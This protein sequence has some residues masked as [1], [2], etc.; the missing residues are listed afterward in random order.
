M[1][2]E[3]RAFV[4][5]LMAVLFLGLLGV[6]AGCQ[7]D[8]APEATGTST[9]NPT[10]ATNGTDVSATPD[11]ETYVYHAE[12][13]P[14]SYDGRNGFTPFACLDGRILAGCWAKVGEDIPEGA[15][16]EYEGQ[17]D[18]YGMKLFSIGP[19][20]SVRAQDG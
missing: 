19:D 16:P 15:K 14:L 12:F 6:L 2:T 10:A 9:P 5:I 18:I 13:A 17:Y 20:G 7:K 8:P 4:I 11:P 3:K 1:I